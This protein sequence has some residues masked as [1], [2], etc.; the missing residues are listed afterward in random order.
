MNLYVRL[1][2]FLVVFGNPDG[3]IQETRVYTS[4]FSEIPGPQAIYE[5]PG[6]SCDFFLYLQPPIPERNLA[7]SARVVR[8]QMTSFVISTYVL[9]LNMSLGMHWHFHTSTS[10]HLKALSLARRMHL[11]SSKIFSIR[12]VTADLISIVNFRRY[13]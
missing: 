3:L 11:K 12:K 9:I 6:T 5:A 2:T 10:S 7:I 13:K 8:R 1:R 4:K